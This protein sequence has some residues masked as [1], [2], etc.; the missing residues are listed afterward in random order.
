MLLVRHHGLKP[1]LPLYLVLVCLAALSGTWTSLFL[2]GL[3]LALFGWKLYALSLP[4]VWWEL[5]QPLYNSFGVAYGSI[6]ALEPQ[7]QLLSLLVSVGLVV[8]V[9]GSWVILPSWVLSRVLSP[10]VIGRLPSHRRP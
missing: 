2:T 1:T 6:L 7:A 9:W 3:V 8:C 10:K 4:L 5:A